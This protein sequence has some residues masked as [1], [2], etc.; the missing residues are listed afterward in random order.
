MKLLR[1]DHVNILTARL[2]LME[3]FY[4]DI[5]GLRVGPRPAFTMAGAWLYLGDQAVVHLVEVRDRRAAV[6]PRIAH[7]AFQA[8]G[9]TDLTDR[10]TG[11]GVPYSVDPVPGLPLVQVNLRDPD[12]N[13]IHVDFDTAEASAGD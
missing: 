10:L 5:L 11:A 8:T 7:F 4:E 12:G 6:N 9:L 13:H 3:R 2:D 1:L